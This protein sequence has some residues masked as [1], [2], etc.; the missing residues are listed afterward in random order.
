[1]AEQKLYQPWTSR[2]LVITPE[3]HLVAVADPYKPKPIL[4]QLPGGKGE[5]KDHHPKGTGF[6]ELW[7]ETGLRAETLELL[8]E[9]QRENWENPGS[10]YAL[11]LYLAKLDRKGLARLK[12]KGDEGEVVRLISWDDLRTMGNFH[13]V[14]KALLQ[15]LGYWPI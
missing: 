13:P 7:E 11:Y 2:V 5:Q 9:E 10:P 14:Y 6:R 3:E 8:Y 4:W 15:T 12:P 1:M